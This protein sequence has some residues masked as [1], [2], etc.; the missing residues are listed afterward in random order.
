MDENQKQILQMLSA[1]QLTV[2][3]AERLIAALEKDRPVSPSGGAQPRHKPQPRYLR[4]VVSDDDSDGD[5][6]TRVNIRVPFQ[7]LRAG[8]K[9]VSLVP[10]KAKDRINDELH[11]N[12]IPF[13]VSQI[14]V[15]DLE[16]LVDQLGELTVDVEEKKST[17]R[18]FVEL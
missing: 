10:E 8:V 14:K 9:L 12:G 2:D 16:A 5:G 1:G 15:E 17:V 6:P 11:K 3:E 13:D 7:L 18:I 4:I